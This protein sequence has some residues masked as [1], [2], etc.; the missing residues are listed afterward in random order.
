MSLKSKIY[1]LLRVYNDVNAVRKG[2]VKHRTGRRVGG[3]IT[4]R[5]LRKLFK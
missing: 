1:R 3:K 5:L 2:R 4:G